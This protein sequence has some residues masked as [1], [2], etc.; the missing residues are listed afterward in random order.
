LQVVGRC[1]VSNKGYS[2]RKFLGNIAA[3]STGA[4]LA[5]MP[6]GHA[7]A[8]AVADPPFPL[9]TVS[10]PLYSATGKLPLEN[11]KIVTTEEI[12]KPDVEKLL[13]VSPTLTLKQCRS[14]DEF[15]REVVDAHVIYAD[16]KREDFAAAKQLRWIQT[17]S[18]GVFALVSWP[19]LV[20]SPVVLTNMQRIYSPGI[21]ETAIGL[22]LS[23]AHG[24]NKYALQTSRHEWHE[25]DED[26]M[27]A[28][29]E[30]RFSNG[31]DQPWNLTD[32]LREVSGYTMGLVGFGGIGTDTAYRAHYGF[33]MKILAV[34]PKPLPKPAWVAELHSLDWLPKMVPQVDVLV[35]AA[36]HTEQSNRMLNESVFRAMKRTSYFINMS[37]GTLVDTPALVRALKEGWIA[38]AGLDVT[39]PEPLP[40]DHPL[41]TA[42][43][44]IITSHTSGHSDESIERAH[45]LF[46][47]N[48]RRYVNGLPLLHVVDKVRGY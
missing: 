8:A 19:E 32:S 15:H 17:R 24:L 7:A 46:C 29:L 20:S 5:S 33:G 3:G 12:P 16:F 25:V 2:R 11:I 26:F 9:T 44:V 4:A 6:V 21:S 28:M 38:G 23:L 43:N 30:R 31:R 13:S 45:D 34:D 39:D 18:A 47:E 41:W 1:P 10:Y 37:R 27:K 35:C 14:W 36:P 48:V 42:G 22:I 40:P